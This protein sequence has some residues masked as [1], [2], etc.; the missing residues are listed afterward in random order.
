LTDKDYKSIIPHEQVV[1]NLSKDKSPGG[2]NLRSAEWAIITQIDGKKTLQEIALILALSQEEAI[3]LFIGLYEKGLIGVQSTQKKEKS[4]VANSFFQT[5]EKELTAVIGPV[6]PFIIDDTLKEMELS[7][8][9]FQTNSVPDLIELLTDEI[10]D[11]SKKIKFQTI[12]LDF[13]K[14]GIEKK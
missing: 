10:S 14:K 8:D 9:Q 1:F 7:Q 2:M 3:N 12:M 6:A 5:L 11:N 4:Y 13:I